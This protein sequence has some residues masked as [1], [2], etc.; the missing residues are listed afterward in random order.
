MNEAAGQ[1]LLKK[2]K[3][4][5]SLLS[6]PLLITVKISSC[7]VLRV[8]ELSEFLRGVIFLC[9]MSHAARYMLL[10]VFFFFF[11]FGT[12]SQNSSVIIKLCKSV[13]ILLHFPI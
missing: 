3:F 5:P 2:K 9:V 7:D 1:V 6:N 10:T 13:T 4:H 11:G 12:D 8:Q